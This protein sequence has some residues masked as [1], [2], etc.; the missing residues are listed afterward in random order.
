MPL[1]RITDL[2]LFV[3]S[4]SNTLRE[5][6]CLIDRSAKGIALVCDQERRLLDT[7]T[8]GDIR[9]AILKNTDLD[10]TLWQLYGHKTKAGKSPKTALIH[11]SDGQVAALMAEYKIRQ[12]P[13]IDETGRVKGLAIDVGVVMDQTNQDVQA[14]VR[15][16]SAHV[17]DH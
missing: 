11:Q 14:V 17:C 2:T 4:T 5:A 13:L 1:Q 12:I 9:R 6:M 10:A 3:T 8:D 16:A 15:A 7:V